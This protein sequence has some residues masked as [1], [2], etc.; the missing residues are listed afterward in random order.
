MYKDTSSKSQ[1][2]HETPIMLLE[3][4]KT[5]PYVSLFER[6]TM[7]HFKNFINVDEAL[8][9]TQIIGLFLASGMW[10]LASSYLI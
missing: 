9:L 4:M 1:N 3:N 8:V 5:F 7:S 10:Q 6:R 2:G